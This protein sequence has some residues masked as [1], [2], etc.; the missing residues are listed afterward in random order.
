MRPEMSAQ[1]IGINESSVLRKILVT[2]ITGGG[3]YLITSLTEQPQIWSLTLSAF[4]GGVALVVQFLVDLEARMKAA[5]VLFGLIEASALQNDVVTQL[6]R[7]ATEIDGDSPA[8]VRSFAQAEI[9]RMSEFL[10]ELADGGDVTYD[11]EDPNWLLGLTRSATSAIDAT[12][13][14]TMD[15]HGKGFVDESFW[16]SDLGL[17]YLEA[18]REAVTRGVIIRR[19][20]ILVEPDLAREPEL[21]KIYKDQKDLGIDVRILAPSMLRGTRRSSIFDFMLFDNIISYEFTPV[22]RVDDATRGGIVNTRLVLR[23]YRVQDRI[24]RFRDLWASATEI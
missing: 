16:D 13:L 10:K 1:H 5:T 15:P 19:V 22:S 12:S 23:D 3:A 21:V 11:G 20:F 2:A 8:L 14:T 18:Q 9:V 7:H 24:Q 6:V 4:I 17:R